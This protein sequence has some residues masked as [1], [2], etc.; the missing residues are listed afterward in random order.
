MNQK[1]EFLL[2]TQQPSLKIYKSSAGS[3]KTYQLVLNYLS[4]ILKSQQ[5]DKFKRILAITFTN[6]ASKEMKE[7]VLQGLRK[8]KEG[9]D[10]QFIKD[11]EATTGMPAHELAAKSEALL[12]RIL[13]NYG[14]LNILTIDKF[15]HRIIR[16]FSR[17]LGLT[18]NFELTF[19][20]DTIIARCIDEVLR[21]LGND[22]QLTQ[23]LVNYYK[24]LI[25]QEDN[26]NIERALL[27]RAK[28]LNQEEAIQ[29]L[30]FYRDKELSFFVEVRKD[31]REK[32]KSLRENSLA[33]SDRV[34]QI[35]GGLLPHLSNGR[36]KY[37]TLLDGLSD[38]KTLPKTLSDAQLRNIQANKWISKKVEKEFPELE[39]IL[40]SQGA[41]LQQLFLEI[42]NNIN[43]ET[44][45]RNLDKN[46]M[47]FALLNDVQQQIQ[48]F[49]EDNNIVLIGELNRII[50]DIIGKESAPYIYEKIGA[51]FEHYFVDEFQDTSVLQWQ[52]LIP[53][54]HDSLSS[55][56]ENLIV[57]DAKQSI[58][59]WRGGNAQQFIDLPKVNFDLIDIQ[60]VN[61]S[62]ETSHQ[63]FTLSD[64][65]RSSQAIIA[66]NNWFFPNLIESFK[67][68]IVSKIYADTEQNPK[69]SDPGYVEI[70]VLDKN[71]DYN[72]DCPYDESL[73]RQLN[74]CLADGYRYRDICILVRSNKDGA[75][76]AQFLTENS[77]P[78]TSQESLLL[79]ESKEIKLLHALLKALYRNTE[80]N[81]IRLF[82]NFQKQSLIELFEKYRIPAEKNDFYHRG[83]D[84]EKFLSV[85]L[86]HFDPVFFSNLSIYDQLDYLVR[87]LKFSREDLYIDKLL[88]ATYDF[89]QR[90]GH[91]TG[92]FMEHLEE[93]VLN[94]S[95]VPPETSNAIV[96]MTIHKSKGLQFPVVIIPKKIETDGN[97]ALWLGGETIADLGLSEI[98]MKPGKNIPDNRIQATKDANDEQTQ[99]DLLNLIYVAY[100][101][102]ENRMYIQLLEYFSKEVVKSQIQLITSHPAYESTSGQLVF[103]E[104]KLFDA[105]QVH[106]EGSTLHVSTENTQ[107][108]RDLLILAT[109]SNYLEEDA[110]FAE[111][112]WGVAIHEIMQN[113]DS[114]EGHQEAINKFLRKNKNWEPNRSE[115]E[116][117]IEKF[118]K[119]DEVQSI[120]KE[121]IAIYSERSLASSYGEILRPDKVIEKAT[122][123]IVI[124]FKTGEA[125][126]KHKQQVLKYAHVL[127]G[128]VEKS[129]QLYLIYLSPQ[130]ITLIHV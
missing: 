42:N 25:D 73:L 84:L 47:S 114:L 75:E 109:P 40:S 130:N 107:S 66:F 20:F 21:E 127:E 12:T 32:I 34:K 81:T 83:F 112:N 124:D 115:I 33:A 113:I 24:Q 13:H 46:L 123:V 121:S 58:Y 97:D 51:R 128:F 118:V 44:F 95:V 54:I 117:V 60:D 89:Q 100:T 41:E 19:D 18:T 69:R 90:F 14:H 93:K 98:N 67:S 86:P 53:L 57:G 82:S 1:R 22:D 56:H 79:K 61:Q 39:Q 27:D 74:E 94:S 38:H 48:Q 104:R 7:R 125:L 15:V 29:K 96:I 106:E 72:K 105:Q 119:N 70:N 30:T 91:Q 110:T 49:K 16:S 71:A 31:I 59:R 87:V 50:S 55:G 28:I 101:R 52:N 99:L 126:P 8:L 65:Y 85:E 77:Y 62:F 17:E 10:H 116:E 23:I 11:Y 76:I 35:L 37:Y 122:E 78:V 88:N 45:L 102:A 120:Y 4:L 92:R 68:P 26:P 36:S 2:E 6:K 64:N 108:W 5:P 103:G 80:E 3:G 129:I 9:T 111:R 63:G 43:K